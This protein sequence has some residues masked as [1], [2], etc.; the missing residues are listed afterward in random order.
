MESQLE[1]LI[2]FS[3]DL[4][5]KLFSEIRTKLKKE[6][7]FISAIHS[8]NRMYI[9][10]FG[11]KELSK[12]VLILIKKLSEQLKEHKLG[13]RDYYLTSCE[14]TFA[15]EYTGKVK[16]PVA[17]T[18]VCNGETCKMVFKDV[19][20]E[21]LRDNLIERAVMLLEEKVSGERDRVI[22]ES[23]TK[24]II[25]KNPSEE[26]ENQG[27]LKKGIIKDEN[28][29][30]PKG[31]KKIHRI[32]E[33]LIKELEETFE[34][35]EI[36]VPLAAPLNLI[37][38]KS[39]IKYIPKEI[40]S[41]FLSKPIDT[42][43]FYEAYYLTGKIPKIET[44]VAGWIF[45]EIPFAFYKAIENTIWNKQFFY[46]V[47]YLKLNMLFF[48]NERKYMDTRKELFN[49]FRKYF[50][51]FGIRYSITSRKLAGM[52]FFKFRVFINKKWVT[53]VELLYSENYYTKPFGIKGKSGHV[54]INLENLFF[55]ELIHTPEAIHKSPI[56]LN[57]KQ[58][59]NEKFNPSPEQ[60]TN[61]E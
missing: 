1:L 49:F 29:Y 19:E 58:E 28:M 23:E 4:D 26:A 41:E 15:C 47:N 18:V 61:K 3:R 13:I 11:D 48:T 43:M 2:K 39:L 6:E 20:K 9:S 12:Y 25:E 34:A 60:G 59:N 46:S 21:F 24:T 56:D 14:I 5:E 50:D 55:L 40:F 33:N 35:E 51:D 16:I 57:P 36:Y 22:F 8:A 7:Y 27:L 30:L 32:K 45:S 37:E 54:I 52:D 10:L 31:V 44:R 17:K 38:D 53:C 42:E